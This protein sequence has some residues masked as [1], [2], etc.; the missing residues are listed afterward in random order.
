MTTEITISPFAIADVEAR[1]DE[2]AG[3]LHACVEE[4]ASINFIHPYSHEDA[5]RFWTKKV[6]PRVSDQELT[7]LVA[8]IDGRIVG[9]VQLDCDTPPNQAHRADIKKLLVHPDF[10]RRGIGRR[11]M[12][13][14]EA[15]ARKL[16]RSLLTL[17]T[18]SG[19]KGEPLYL[20]IGFIAAG[21]I[22]AYARDA[23][24]ER[25][26]AATFMYKPLNS[27]F[28]EVPPAQP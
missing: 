3:L 19:D 12:G 8:Q 28:R 9:S 1:L 15:V 26:D 5:K 2:L 10:Q 17:D 4:G 22:P 27:D 16:G 6:L 25:L 24:S 7:V 18:R 13:E 21:T 23:R 20:S 14:I 11:L